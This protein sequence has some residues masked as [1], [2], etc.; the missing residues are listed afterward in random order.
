MIIM[1][2]KD[3]NF[4]YDSDK[5]YLLEGFSFKL[6]QGEHVVLTGRNGAG[7][8]TVAKLVSGLISPDAGI[9][10]LFG[11]TCFDNGRVN[12]GAYQDARKSIAF[13]AQDPSLQ[14]LCEN[15]VSD[16]AF[17]PQNLN[18]SVEKIDNAVSKQLE[19]AG[20]D[21]LAEKDPHALS[22]GEQQIVSLACAIAAD[23][24]L[25]VID[26]PTSF[27]DSENSKHFLRLLEKTKGE[28]TIFHVTHK[29]EEIEMADREV[30][31]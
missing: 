6:S 4:S 14:L 20:I 2:L 7:K 8:S 9:V 15:V 23:P 29:D 11:K 18:W 13:V 16:I 1:E 17:A 27:L 10:K 21:Y 28:R 30:R 25:L 22:G 31:M 19:K 26:E 12:V 3:I 5:S 24:R